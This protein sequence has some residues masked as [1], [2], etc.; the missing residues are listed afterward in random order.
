MVRFNPTYV[1]IVSEKLSVYIGY[2]GNFVTVTAGSRYRATACGLCG[3]Y[4]GN[5]YDD[6]VGPDPTCKALGPN[7]MMK[8]YIQREGNCAGVG[9]PCPVSA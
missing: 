5:K 2:A 1:G 3:N 9:S 6:F 8:A 4:N 7:D